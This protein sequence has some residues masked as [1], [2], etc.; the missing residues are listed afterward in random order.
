MARQRPQQDEGG[1]NWMDT[2]GD[3]VTLLLTFFVLLFAFS[4]VDDAKWNTLVQAFT[5]QPPVRSIAAVELIDEP[6]FTEYLPQTHVN[7]RDLNSGGETQDESPDLS[8]SVSELSPEQVEMLQLALS[9]EQVE[10]M[11]TE[12][13]QRNEEEFS[14]LYE[15]LVEYIETNGLQDMLHA[16][17]DL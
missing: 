5:G 1:S 2:Y 9:Q 10:I 16:D 7:L 13:Y 4:S 6:D 3:M 17:R 14:E 12:E 8:F 15:R 11:G